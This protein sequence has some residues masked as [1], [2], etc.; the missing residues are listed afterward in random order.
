MLPDIDPP[1]V[2]TPV[3]SWGHPRV[4]LREAVKAF[5][6]WLNKPTKAERAHVGI[7]NE[8]L[9]EWSSPVCE[10]SASG[11]A[12]QVRPAVPASSDPTPP[13]HEG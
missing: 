8:A 2:W 9:R 13:Q 11:S 4:W 1:P 3:T 10:G 12:P 5:S 6:A 7:G